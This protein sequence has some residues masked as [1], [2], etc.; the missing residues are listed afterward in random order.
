MLTSFECV[1]DFHLVSTAETE[2]DTKDVLSLFVRER[3]LFGI[4]DQISLF[5]F[6]TAT[7]LS[8]LKLRHEDGFRRH[9][10]R[11]PTMPHKPCRP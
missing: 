2:L 10:Q 9:N 4:R 11:R 3:M 5:Q 6:T 7:I 8:G 1:R